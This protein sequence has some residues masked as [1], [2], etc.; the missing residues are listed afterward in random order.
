MHSVSSFNILKM[1]ASSQ[2]GENDEAYA[3]Y[4]FDSKR[5]ADLFQELDVNKDGRIDI[6]ELTTGLKKL[7]VRHV[8]GQ[9]EVQY[10]R[11]NSLG[12]G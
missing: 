10:D 4:K 12:Q 2:G 11:S 6:Q 8:P 5:I 7:G 1:A 3:G 9:V